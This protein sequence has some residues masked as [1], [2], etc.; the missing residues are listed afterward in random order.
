VARYNFR[1]KHEALG[2]QTVAMASGA[3]DHVWSVKELVERAADVNVHQSRCCDLTI[4]GGDGDR[5]GRGPIFT[6]GS[7][8]EIV[9]GQRMDDQRADREGELNH[10]RR[11]S[12]FVWITAAALNEV[13][14]MR[15][16]I[17]VGALRMGPL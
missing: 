13:F 6:V 15:A 12:I 14:T 8:R 11:S 9:N 16:A 2:K 7:S 5:M 4:V 17:F 10:R 1:R 3:S